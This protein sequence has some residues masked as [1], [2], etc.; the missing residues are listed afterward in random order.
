VRFDEEGDGPMNANDTHPFE[1]GLDRQPSNYVP[2]SPVSFLT[3]A[4]SASGKLAVI[5]GAR[6]LTHAQLLDR[7]TRLASALAQAEDKE[8]VAFCQ[9][10]LARFKVPKVVVYGALPKT[11][12]GNIQKFA[13]CDQ[14]GAL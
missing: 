1:V 13:L 12:T 3:R 9:A 6:R 5:D 14:A 2:L 11:S 7:C 10:R 4:A 8:I